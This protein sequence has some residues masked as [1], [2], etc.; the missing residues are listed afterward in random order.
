MVERYRNNIRPVGEPKSFKGIPVDYGKYIDSDIQRA[1]EPFL[2]R[3]DETYNEDTNE[4][5]NMAEEVRDNQKKVQILSDGVAAGSMLCAQDLGQIYMMGEI[6][7]QDWNKG[8]ELLFKAARCGLPI[9]M[10]FLGVMYKKVNE[11]GMSKDPSYLSKGLNWIC[12]AAI[13]GNVSAYASLNQYAGMTYD[14]FHIKIEDR[15]SVYFKMICDKLTKT[16]S[17]LKFL[18]FCYYSGF[19]FLPSAAEARKLWIEGATGGK[20]SLGGIECRFLLD[21]ASELLKPAKSQKYNLDMGTPFRR[22]FRK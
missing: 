3:Q 15:L 22:W 14:S 8:E 19:C 13:R 5:W 6:V 11:S 10:Y 18:G 9:S 2:N 20:N 17:E 12:K 4:Y 21:N 1:F 16:P 7:K